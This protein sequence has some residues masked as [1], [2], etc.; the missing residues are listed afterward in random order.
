MTRITHYTI[1]NLWVEGKRFLEIP[2]LITP[3]GQYDLIIRI[4]WFAENDVWL[5]C[6]NWKLIWLEKRE[7][8]LLQQAEV[9]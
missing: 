5:D 3:L 2:I 6:K 9:I 1:L 7:T 8:P 4:N